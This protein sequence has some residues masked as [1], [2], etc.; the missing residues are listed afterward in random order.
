[1]IDLSKNVT[2]FK[3]GKK[4]VYCVLLR[5]KSGWWIKYC[6]VENFMPCKSGRDSLAH[7]YSTSIMCKVSE[8]EADIFMT[9]I[10]FPFLY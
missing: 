1:M 6:A 3:R 4:E 10:F 9:L 5:L 8:F 2:P 7:F